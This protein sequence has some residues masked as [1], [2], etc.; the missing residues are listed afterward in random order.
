[1]DDS[2]KEALIALQLHSASEHPPKMKIITKKFHELS[3]MHHPDRPGGDNIIY[4]K[5]T[6][7]YRIIG[8]YIEKKYVPKKDD[9]EEELARHAFRHFNFNDIKENLSS[10][11]IK[12]DN[13]L[14]F[15]W[16]KI[17]TKHYG[18]PIDRK[19]NGKHWKHL[20]YSDDSLNKGH[21]A[22]GKWH[23]PKKDKQSKLNIQSSEVGNFLPAHFVSTHLPKLLSEVKAIANKN[24]LG[25]SPLAQPSK[26]KQKHCSI[27][28]FKAGSHVELDP[29]MKSVHTNPSVIM[30]LQ[31]AAGTDI[32][33]PLEVLPSLKSFLEPTIFKC[34]ICSDNY[35][36]G[37]WD[38][39]EKSVHV[40][41]YTHVQNVG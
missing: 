4:Q 13:H 40:Q 5:I 33:S 23:I 26:I 37:E 17:L 27:C 8:D 30:Q 7:A 12:I 41:L 15:F 14:S 11:T 29:H 34:F 18:T 22:I 19:A 32:S 25:H 16:D 28:Y 38:I 3:L 2:V 35:N 20:D 36:Q 21:I 24:L 6:E 10:F 39:H 9:H 31:L 1:M